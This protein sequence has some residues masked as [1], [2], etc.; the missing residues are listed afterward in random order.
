MKKTLFSTL[1][2][3]GMIGMGAITS[4]AEDNAEAV[5]KI[6]ANVISGGITI[7]ADPTI[8]FPDVEIN[9]NVTATSNLT[10]DNNLG[11]EFQL[12]GKLNQAMPTGLTLGSAKGNF[13]DMTTTAT[14]I[15][16]SKTGSTIENAQS[17][18][19]NDLTVDWRLAAGITASTGLSNRSVT[20]TASPK[21]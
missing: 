17:P 1:A 9:S 16:W 21:I 6:S 8:T 4:H 18:G 2:L 10:V 12:N 3:I 14:P 13:N 7:T 15:S 19:K 20:F 11:R 5:T